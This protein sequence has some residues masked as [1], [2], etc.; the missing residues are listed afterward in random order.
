MIKYASSSLFSGYLLV[1]GK[2][3]SRNVKNLISLAGKYKVKVEIKR[4]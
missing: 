2:V 4:V 1:L 3:S